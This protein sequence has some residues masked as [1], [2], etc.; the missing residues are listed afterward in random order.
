MRFDRL[1]VVTL[2]AILGLAMVSAGPVGSHNTVIKSETTTPDDASTI[3][4]Y[5]GNVTQLNVVGYSPTQTWQ[6]YFGNVTGTIQ[7]ADS[8]DNVMYNWSLAS[9]EGEIYASQ[10]SSVDW[11]SIYCF[12]F[13]ST[14]ELIDEPGSNLPGGTATNGKNLNILES[15]FNINSDDVDGIDETFTGHSHSLFYTNNL[16]FGQGQCQSVALRGENGDITATNFEEVLLYDSVNHDV[17]FASLLD[18][19]SLA[20][21]D[22]NDYDFEMLVLEDGHG[23]DTAVTPYYFYVE[24]E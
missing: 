6:G 17:I 2:V 5:A 23:T 1:F 22:G 8:N 19:E 20:G 18:E 9:P 10:I 12:N 13:S 15:E 14:G 21:F 16:E 3:D 24:L 7:L 4:A 11:G